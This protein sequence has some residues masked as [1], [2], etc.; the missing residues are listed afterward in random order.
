VEQVL[1]LPGEDRIGTDGARVAIGRT[2]AG[3]FLKVVYVPEPDGAFVLTAYELT[4][5][6]LLAYRRRCRRRGDR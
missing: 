4:G 1:R 2:E 5:K 3:R 6:P